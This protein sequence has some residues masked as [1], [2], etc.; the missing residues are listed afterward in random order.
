MSRTSSKV[1]IV[2]AGFVGSTA[3]LRCA[4]KG[5]DEVVLIDVAGGIAR[6][7]ALDMRQ[8]RA[9]DQFESCVTGTDDYAETAG[10]DIVVIT[11][12][13][14]RKPGMLREELVSINGGVVSEVIERAREASPDALF[15]CVTNPLDVMTYLAQKRS[16]IAPERL[17]GMGG[18]LDSARFVAS[19]AAELDVALGEVDGLVIGAHGEGMVPLIDE[20]RVSGRLLREAATPAQIESIVEH[21]VNG[22]AEI[23]NFLQTGSAYFAPGAAIAHMVEACLKNSGELMSVCAYLDGPYGQHD[24]YMNVPVRLGHGGVREIVELDISAEERAAL[25]ASGASIA[26]LLTEAGLR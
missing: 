6:G 22:G 8:M 16:G 3:A 9:I 12:G 11:A 5:I 13:I 19:I 23:V 18:V 1:T 25:D 2:G 21:T 15:M 17:F 4:Q 10:S 26:T 24:L 7:K 20:A 14:A